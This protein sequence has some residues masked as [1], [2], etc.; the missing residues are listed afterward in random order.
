MR[1]LLAVF[2][3]LL[4]VLHWASAEA[5]D[6]YRFRGRPPIPASEV[7]RAIQESLDEFGLRPKERLI[8][9]VLD[10]E[11]GRDSYESNGSHDGLFSQS[12][13]HWRGRVESFNRA[14]PHYPVTGDVF[15][16]FD[17]VRV[18]FWMMRNKPSMSDWIEC[19]P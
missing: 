12:R 8:Y 11:S 6:K 4:S 13:K 14:H 16:A 2:V 3:A 19:L 15:N 17:N 10:C 9:S 5:S 7:E 1:K 18:S